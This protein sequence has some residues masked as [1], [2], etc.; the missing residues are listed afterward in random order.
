MSTF[1]LKI[2]ASDKVFYDGDC[3]ILV[4]PGVDG[5]LAVMAHH[6]NMV[7]A[8]I[9]G[10]IRFKDGSSDEYHYAVVGIGFVH[11]SDNNVTMLVDTVER[12]ED[13]DANRAKSALERAEEQLRHK[14][15]IQEY[16]VSQASLLRAMYRLKMS[17]KSGNNKF[18]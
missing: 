6:Q 1:H 7:V 14:Q 5:E 18:I 2:I 8:T 11:I 12:P 16:H 15:S 4:V 17:G 9:V 3:E 13:I 10:D